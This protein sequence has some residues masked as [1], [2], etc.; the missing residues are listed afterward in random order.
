M[1]GAQG[2]DFETWETTDS[3]VRK[4]PVRDRAGEIL[5]HQC[6]LPLKWQHDSDIVFASTLQ[7]ASAG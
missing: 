6:N 1:L 2:L 3:T 5:F 7:D 4:H